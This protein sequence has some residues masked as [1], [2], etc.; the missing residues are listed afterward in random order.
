MAFKKLIF[1]VCTAFLFFLLAGCGTNTNKTSGGNNEESPKKD[2]VAAT[3]ETSVSSKEVNNN[4]IVQY[5]MK[6]ISGKTLNLTFPTGLK[7]DYIIYDEQEK[8]VKQYSDDVLAT[9]AIVEVALEN[10]KEISQEFT[11]SDLPNGKY[12]MEIFLTA[13]EEKASGFMDLLIENSSKITGSGVLVGQM[14]P[15][16][17]EIMIDGIPTAF[18]LTEEAQLQLPLL[19]DGETISFTYTKQVIEG[20]LEQKTI[21][22]F[23]FE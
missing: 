15:H 19:K 4:T 13:K 23:I 18:Q 16:T 5:K 12:V 8:K 2:K 21:E 11:I 20:D 14:D 17:I 9:Q 7:V 1:V 3:F 22:K 10:G 6:N